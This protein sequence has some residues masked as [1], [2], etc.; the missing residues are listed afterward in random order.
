MEWIT[1]YLDHNK[2]YEFENNLLPYLWKAHGTLL[3]M[4]GLTWIA[5]SEQIDDNNYR[6]LF[7]CDSRFFLKFIKAFV[8][9]FSRVHSV[10]YIDD[11]VCLSPENLNT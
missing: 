8:G 1:F 4:S 10:P 7:C 9:D 6:Y 5:Y 11:M 3:E 2:K